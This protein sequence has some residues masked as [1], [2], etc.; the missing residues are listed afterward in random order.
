MLPCHI[1]YNGINNSV[2]WGGWGG[3]GGS[4]EDIVKMTFKETRAG[5]LEKG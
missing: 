5:L 3:G 2:G 1:A 4:V